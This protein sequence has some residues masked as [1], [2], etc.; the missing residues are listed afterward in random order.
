MRLPSI[1]SGASGPRAVE[2]SAHWCWKRP[3]TTAGSK[4]T[5]LP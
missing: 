4:V 2:R 3:I 5:G 1:A